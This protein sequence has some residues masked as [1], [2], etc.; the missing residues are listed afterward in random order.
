MPNRSLFLKMLPGAVFS[1]QKEPG[2]KPKTPL[3]P[4]H[5]AHRLYTIPFIEF[6]LIEL[7]EQNQGAHKKGYHH[8][9]PKL[10]RK[11]GVFGTK[12]A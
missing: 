9:G 3:I 12:A 1:R 6:I 11:M 5:A 2:K 10:M 8:F 4:Q 7:C